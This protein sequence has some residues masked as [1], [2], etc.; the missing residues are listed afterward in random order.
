M[1]TSRGQLGELL[2]KVQ[3]WGAGYLPDDDEWWMLVAAPL[4]GTTFL[5]AAFIIMYIYG[6]IISPLSFGT[7]VIILSLCFSVILLTNVLLPIGLYFDTDYIRQTAEWDPQTGL[8]LAG[9]LISLI[10][11]PFADMTAI[12]YL[13]HR[14][15]KTSFGPDSLWWVHPLRTRP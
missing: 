3:D 15:E 13:Y 10:V 4:L 5:F 14:V 2:D 11:P 6:T 1:A 8:Y 7:V 12:V 9:A